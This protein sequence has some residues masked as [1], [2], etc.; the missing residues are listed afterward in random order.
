MRRWVVN[1]R[2]AVGMPLR[3]ITF[4]LDHFVRR[5]ILEAMREATAGYWLRRAREFDDVHGLPPLPLFTDDAT[6]EAAPSAQRVA[7][8][9]RRQEWLLSTGQFDEPWEGFNEDFDMV[10]AGRQVA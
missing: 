5:L 3:K 6:V 10:S 7:L 9:C 8:A 2:P 4:D 1:V